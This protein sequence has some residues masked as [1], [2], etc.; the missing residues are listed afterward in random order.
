MEIDSITSADHGHD[1]RAPC[2]PTKIAP[3]CSLASPNSSLKVV[4]LVLLGKVECS[5]FGIPGP[6][7]IYTLHVRVLQVYYNY[8]YYYY[9]YYYC[10]NKHTYEPFCYHKLEM[11]K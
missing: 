2:C 11:S 3:P 9:H 8:T 1:L 4:F 7:R 6:K 5:I 10:N